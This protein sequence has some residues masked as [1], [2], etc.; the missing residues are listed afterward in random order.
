MKKTRVSFFSLMLTVSMI[1]SGFFGCAKTVIDNNETF[2]DS[3]AFTS[4]EIITSTS[5]EHSSESKT[6]AT[7]SES[8]AN[9]DTLETVNNNDTSTS[10]V[11][12][13]NDDA[14]VTTDAESSYDTSS[15][16]DAE[17]NNDT[18][19]PTES[20]N[21]NDTFAE[22]DSENN[23][24]ESTEN[25]DD[26]LSKETSEITE[27]F[28]EVTAPTL[29]GPYADIIEVSNKYANGVNA[30]YTDPTRGAFI[31]QNNNMSLTNTL[32]P[33]EAKLVSSIKNSVGKS[34]IENTMDV[35]VKMMDGGTFFAS[36]SLNAA[37]VN[38]DR[39][40]YYYYQT[41][42][43][44][45]NFTGELIQNS[46][47]NLNVGIPDRV[48]HMTSATQND[49]GSISVSVINTTDPQVQYTSIEPFAADEYNYLAITAKVDCA[50]E[51]LLV[52][53]Q[54]FIAAGSKTGFNSSQSTS[55]KMVGDGEYHTYFIRIDRLPDYT[56]NVTKIRLD[57]DGVLNDT[58]TIKEIKAVNAS[59]NN[60]PELFMRRTFNT[61]TDRNL[62]VIQVS[63]KVDTTGIDSIGMITS[64]N[65]ATVEKII[66]KS[67]GKLYTA[68]DDVDWTT[69]EYIGFDI[70][71]VGIFGYIMLNDTTSGNIQVT[72]ED[73]YYRITQ[74]RTPNNNTILKP[75]ESSVNA[76][77]FYMGQRIYTD[78]SHDFEK[79]VNEAECERNPIPAENI[80]IK[81]P[82]DSG[83]YV[84]YN[85]LRGAYEFTLDDSGFN[86]AYFNEANKHYTVTFSIKG[87]DKDR[88][89]YMMAAITS[90]QLESAVVLDGN[91]ELLPV[92]VEVIKNFS[93]GDY[94]IHQI[95]DTTWSESFFPIPVKAETETD[96]TLLHLYQNWGRFPL[97]Q[98][99]SIKF[100]C[101]YYH[102]STGVIETNCILPW[103]ITGG[104][105]NVFSTL[106]DHRAMS[107]PFWGNQPQ[108]TSGGDHAFLHYTDS[109]GKFIA[110]EVYK[111]TITSYGPTY[112]EVIT[113][114]FSDDGKIK[115]SYTHMEM[116]QIDE[117]RGYY[118]ITYDVIE[119]VTVNNFKE[120]FAIYAMIPK[121]AVTYQNI[122]YLNEN[123]ECKVTKTNTKDK[124][125]YYVLGDNCPYF[126]YFRDDDCAAKDGYVNLSCLILN[127]EIIIGGEKVTPKFVISDFNRTVTLSL[128]IDGQVTL[129]AGD[130][131]AL[132]AII[133]PW[134]S[135]VSDYDSDEFAP[136][137][138][139]RDVRKNSLL[140]PLRITETN[141]CNDVSSAFLPTVRSNDGISAEFTVA[142][143][144]NNCTVKINGL[145]NR[146][147]PTVMELV[148][149]EWVRY[150]L[151]SRYY[152]DKSDNK[153]RYDGYGITYED[154]GFYS[155]SFVVEMTDGEPRTF[156]F[157]ADEEQ[158][159]NEVKPPK[160]EN[161]EV[162]GG[163]YAGTN[164]YYNANA[165][166]A[167]VQNGRGIGKSEILNDDI[168]F[169]RI[170]G[171]N[172]SAEAF[173]S[174]HQS[175]NDMTGI[176]TGQ[177]F[178]FKYRVASDKPENDYFAL[179]SS[180]EEAFAKQEHSISYTRIVKDGQWHVV[181]VNYADAKPNAFKAAENGTYNAQYLRFDVLNA[182]TATTSYVDIAFMAFDDD[183]NEVLNLV[184][185]AHETIEYY[186]GEYHTIN[187]ANGV[188]PEKTPDNP[189]TPD[190]PE[191]NDGPL[192]V[193][194]S[195]TNMDK[196][197]TNTGNRVISEDGEYITFYSLKD[198][199]ESNVFIY[200]NTGNPSG[201]YLIFK[202]RS[203]AENYIQF[204]VTTESSLASSSNVSLTATNNLYINDGEWHV[205]VINLASALPDHYQPRT[206]G[207]FYATTVRLDYFNTMQSS[208]DVT[209]D[210][211]YVGMTDNFNE[212]IGYDDGVETI[213]FFDG[214]NTYTFAAKDAESAIEPGKG[215]TGDDN[216]DDT[217][218]DVT[219]E[220]EEEPFLIYY[221]ATE[222]AEYSG[223]G[224]G[225]KKVSDDKS[226]IT[227]YSNATS[228]ESYI[229]LLNNRDNSMV[230]GQYLILKY[231]TT[232]PAT[233]YFDFFTTT[234]EKPTGFIG[235][236]H[237]ALT[238]NKK[239][240]VADNTWQVVV[241]DLAAVMPDYYSADTNGDYKASYL[242]F[243]F[244]NSKMNSTEYTID[245]AYVG[246]HDD[247]EEIKAYDK[248][249]TSITYYDGTLQTI[250]VNQ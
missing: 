19:A 178:V 166:L 250:S 164:K 195:P 65:A 179:F 203:T 85:A 215:N 49:D 66:V 205:V 214:N 29:E 193:L 72:L 202:Y 246:L 119:D 213:L 129:K 59:D 236:A 233:N 197:G 185:D 173:F 20:E 247:L 222:L 153:N 6:E 67:E 239:L 230:T 189:D 70:K 176:Q 192:N 167:A 113:D 96:Y 40:G 89:I 93:D 95:V 75:S 132:N 226:Y 248:T 1:T 83:A 116:P 62:Q 223:A 86:T 242:R 115:V 134:G 101:P 30:Y 117:N 245:V 64:I 2:S 97:K 211:A 238:D 44:G 184:K 170:Y 91:R 163:I 125:K 7:V 145:I 103:F 228:D 63:A 154:D 110:T 240:Y 181:V 227:F 221:S 171:N 244:F 41:V 241:I 216:E 25:T 71:D 175:I 140:N 200:K 220:P 191:V 58:F 74:S 177:F 42:I 32:L 232:T 141:G 15:E 207:K 57:L 10:T 124:P 78:E 209:I 94:S 35:F 14:S 18:S 235:A 33:P 128:N 212:A 88:I 73:G 172:S 106:P 43:S 133:M 225:E 34:Y 122:G 199:P 37:T 90:G 47:K 204:F 98:I 45:Q 16:T 201:E 56:G 100:G 120:D 126:S 161:E 138:N 149:G 144:N 237:V 69:A 87:D 157:I 60:A 180:T 77:D 108:H 137:Q 182:V 150:N 11:V 84:G 218:S 194:I 139:V 99:S 31:I 156:K 51:C 27:S 105:K 24:F 76:N 107:A 114:H 174:I 68:L 21:S 186:N 224:L 160:T 168:D 208:D 187:T 155:Y 135:Q 121:S 142:G 104:Q 131:I 12:E 92:P 79:F 162:M 196:S 109:E 198:A 111:N 52:G 152:P 234:Q 190:T 112:A 61:Y 22:T 127:S 136:D 5:V 38:I 23:P 158:F 50:G 3:E 188:M 148:D 8:S 169:I 13:S 39:F 102:L 28:A 210:V 9:S 36:N 17:S 219:P 243:D 229:T 118:T 48:I 82:S 54:L 53:G 80:T 4:Q 147:I 143:G 206:D 146:T 46:E 159:V 217:S 26:T 123:N 151:S 81:T 231:R 130:R 55:F 249:A 183:F 165:I